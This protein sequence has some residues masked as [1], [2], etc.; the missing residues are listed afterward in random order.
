ML[1]V[2]HWLVSSPWAH[3]AEMLLILLGALA[4]GPHTRSRRSG[5]LTPNAKQDP[6]GAITPA[7]TREGWASTRQ[8]GRG[9][10]LTFEQLSRT[11]T[12]TKRHGGFKLQS[13]STVLSGTVGGAVSSK[14][15]SGS[16]GEAA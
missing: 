15:G 2:A 11:A 6:V 3:L 13:L 1:P 4:T 9:G 14:S 16:Y 10:M 8:R 7:A 5:L 12:P